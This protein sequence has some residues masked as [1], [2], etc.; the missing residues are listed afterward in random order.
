L[1][2]FIFLR[3]LSFGDEIKLLKNGK[4]I[5]WLGS[6]RKLPVLQPLGDAYGDDNNCIVTVYNNAIK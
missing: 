1:F 6:F 5:T 4:K 2:I 3:F